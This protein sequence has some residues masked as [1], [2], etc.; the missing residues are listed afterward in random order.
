MLALAIISTVILS[1]II[2]SYF[3][4]NVVDGDYSIFGFTIVSLLAFV[5]VTIWVLYA[6]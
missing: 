4:T 6:R 2:L 1:F 5:I 3:G